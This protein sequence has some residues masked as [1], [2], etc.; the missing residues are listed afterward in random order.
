MTTSCYRAKQ[1]LYQG[2]TTKHT[3]R[4][5]EVGVMGGVGKFAR[6]IATVGAAAAAPRPLEGH[7]EGGALLPH[8]VVVTTV[9]MAAFVGAL[10]CH[11]GGGGLRVLF[12][13]AAATV[14]A[15]AH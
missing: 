8:V 5:D 12:D 14:A 7:V 4:G 1:A 9:A 11:V 3:V 2:R 6:Q 10:A 15:V 13:A